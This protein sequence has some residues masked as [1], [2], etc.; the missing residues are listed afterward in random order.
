MGQKDPSVR[1]HTSEAVS[2]YTP[3]GGFV[4][5]IASASHMDESEL[6]NRGRDC[7]GGRLA[8]PHRLDR[9]I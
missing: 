1:A 2:E 3:L 5:W 6:L 9:L 7:H 8:I 4:L